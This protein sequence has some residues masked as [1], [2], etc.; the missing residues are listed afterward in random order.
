MIEKEEIN[1]RVFEIKWNI[2][3]HYLVPKKWRD[4]YDIKV[5]FVDVKNFFE[6]IWSV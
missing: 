5:D 6:K 4:N 2:N 3:N 1:L